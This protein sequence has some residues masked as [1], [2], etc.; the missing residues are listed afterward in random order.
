MFR[1]LFSTRKPPNL[2]FKNLRTFTNMVMSSDN[3]ALN[4]KAMKFDV[5]AFSPL[6]TVLALTFSYVDE[7]S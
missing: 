6:S 3:L 2:V 5:D 7:T 4:R 1:L